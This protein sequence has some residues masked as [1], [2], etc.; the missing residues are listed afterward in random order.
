MCIFLRNFRISLISVGAEKDCVF[1]KHSGMGQG[2]HL[3]ITINHRRKRCLRSVVGH[4]VF[5]LGNKPGILTSAPEGLF[6]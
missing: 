5:N 4:V 3:N 6:S 1:E 2:E